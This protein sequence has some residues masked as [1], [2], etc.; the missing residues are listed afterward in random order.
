MFVQITASLS[1]FIS[2][3]FFRR[4][5]IKLLNDIFSRGKMGITPERPILL[6]AGIGD[7]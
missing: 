6:H 3:Q 1:V 4:R 2:G 7:N 5:Y